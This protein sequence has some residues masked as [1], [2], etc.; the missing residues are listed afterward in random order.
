MTALSVLAYATIF[1]EARDATRSTHTASKT[2]RYDA[3]R[4][5]FTSSRPAAAPLPDDDT[6]GL[7][8]LARLCSVEPRLPSS[9]RPANE[10]PADTLIPDSDASQAVVYEESPSAMPHRHDSIGQDVGQPS[11]T[12]SQPP[13]TAA[14]L[15]A[16]SMEPSAYPIQQDLGMLHYPQTRP[17][18]FA[19]HHRPYPS[20][21]PPPPTAG[22]PLQ[23]QNAYYHA[24]SG[25]PTPNHRDAHMVSVRPVDTGF[26]MASYGSEAPPPPAQAYGG[27]VYWSQHP[28]QGPS[29]IAPVAV[30]VQH[31]YPPP[32]VPPAAPHPRIPFSH[33]AS[34]EPLPPLR[35]P[36]SR[37][38]AVHEEPVHDARM[39]A[40]MHALVNP[41]YLPAPPR[42]AFPRGYTESLH[43]TSQPMGLERVLPS[44]HHPP[45]QQAYMG[46]PPP[47]GF[48]HQA[49][50]AMSP[51]FGNPLATAGQMVQ[52][53]PPDT[54]Q[55][56]PIPM[57]YHRATPCNDA[58]NGKYRKLQPAPIPAHRAWSNKPELKT[59]F[60]DHKETGSSAALPNSGPTQIRGWN[61]NQSRKRS[62]QDKG[63][64]ANDREDSR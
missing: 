34:A 44:P 52:Q 24:P 59:I 8:F 32:P 2:S 64:Y 10:A 7:N 16:S 29:P 11:F 57:L 38:Q 60:Y 15:H 12:H 19:Q 9:A 18:E 25:Y 46:S 14:A 35:P 36:R 55:V 21:Q 3:I 33:N 5:V 54:P 58:A 51:S 27:L 13:Q 42:A 31:Q 1:E 43:P 17:A 6:L 28:Q 37:S 61:V 23:D 48:A 62:R 4:D 41:Y 63:D 45:Q 20:Q 30:P 49:P 40:G 26:R 53:S 50:Q 39:R 47:L 22:H 56:V